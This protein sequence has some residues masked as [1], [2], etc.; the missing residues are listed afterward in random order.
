MKLS[1]EWR[2]VCFLSEANVFCPLYIGEHDPL[3]RSLTC[4]LTHATFWTNALAR[5]VCR[6]TMDNAP[7]G[8]YSIVAAAAAA[9]AEGEEEEEEEEE[10]ESPF[11]TV[12]AATSSPP[13]PSPSAPLSTPT[14]NPG[15]PT[16]K[17]CCQGFNPALYGP[18]LTLDG[19]NN[20][21]SGQ[22]RG[23]ATAGGTEP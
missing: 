10:E 5:A 9:A 4:P 11:P 21:L 16:N 22:T 1:R 20:L 6:S 3:A 18:S 23:S 17:N 14:S 2:L 19:S 7:M 12:A 15:A 13:S 8:R